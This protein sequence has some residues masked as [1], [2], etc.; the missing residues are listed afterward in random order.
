SARLAIG[1]GRQQRLVPLELCP[2]DVSLMVILQQNLAVL[3]RFAVAVAFAEAAIDDLRSLLAF[4]V[5][6]CSCVEGI[7]QHRDHIAV[8]DGVP[9]KGDRGPAVRRSRKMYLLGAHPQQNLSR[10]TALLEPV[11]DLTNDFLDTRVRIKTETGLSVPAVSD[12]YWN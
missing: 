3:K 2:S 9:Y 6:I 7:L 12:W 8:P 5:G 1:V 10:A 4:A 11:E